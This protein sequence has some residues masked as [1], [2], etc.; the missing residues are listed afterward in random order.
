M[1]SLFP[2]PM[3]P[4]EHSSKEK[5]SSEEEEKEAGGKRK[6]RGGSTGPKDGPVRPQNPEEE[7]TGSGEQPGSYWLAVSLSRGHH[8]ESEHVNWNMHKCL[9]NTEV[10]G[11]PWCL[12]GGVRMTDGAETRSDG[13]L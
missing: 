10:L 11:V 9:R 13:C 12:R 6:R 4:T 5:Q 2:T 3:L 1:R 7:A 8:P